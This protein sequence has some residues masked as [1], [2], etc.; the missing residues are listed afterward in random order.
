[1]NKIKNEINYN[2]LVNPTFITGQAT[3]EMLAAAGNPDAV[4]YKEMLSLNGATKKVSA[5][6]GDANQIF[7][8]EE[9]RALMMGV[10]L[11]IEARYAAVSR[12]LKESGCKSMLDIASGYT[13]R[14]LMCQKEG[15]DYVGLDL[16]A[17]VDKMAPL[18]EKLFAA[19]NHPAYI[20]G[21]ATNAASIKAAA[22]M[23]KGE[24]FVTCE[25]LLTYLNKSELEQTIKGIREVLLEHGGAWYSSDMGVMYDHF[26]AVAIN[27][28]DVLERWAKIMSSIKKETDVYFF[29]ATFNTVEEKI[30]FFEDRGLHVELIPFYT[31]DTRLNILYGFDAEGQE[32]MKHLMKNF[33]IWKM[34]VAEEKN[35]TARQVANGLDI[36]YRYNKETLSVSLKGRLDTLSA[37]ELM[38]LMDELVEKEPFGELIFD[39]E[40]LEYLSSTGL[41]VFLMMAKRF[42]SDHLFVDNANALI[43][44]IFETTGFDEVVVIR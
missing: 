42:G 35:E 36:I 44:E 24:L 34:T 23:L 1:M 33:H 30:A 39:L 25:G 43:R 22:D 15:I 10:T 26:S 7:S 18:A 38:K 13:P 41:R 27:K 16:P 2:E 8:P 3:L 12:L 28:P 37:P 29:P 31:D 32:R 17:V 5:A 19:G 4:T 9:G 14:A 20:A 21:D 11:G 6:S 40:N